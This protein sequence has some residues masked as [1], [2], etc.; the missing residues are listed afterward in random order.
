[1]RLSKSWPDVLTP[2]AC[3]EIPNDGTLDAEL[4]AVVAL[5]APVHAQQ[6]VVFCAIFACCKLSCL[7]QVVVAVRR[8]QTFI[9]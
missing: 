3:R 4:R 5:E 7:P 2:D 6:A 1:M 9:V 8:S